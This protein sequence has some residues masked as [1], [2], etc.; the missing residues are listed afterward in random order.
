MGYTNSMQIMQGDVTHTLQEEIPK[1]TIPFVDDVPVKGP[2]SRYLLPDGT[3]RNDTR[4]SGNTPVHMGA[5]PDD[6][7]DTTKDEGSWRDVQ[8]QET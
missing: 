2:P 1:Y 4:Q 5:P 6:E 8:W 7:Q 3:L